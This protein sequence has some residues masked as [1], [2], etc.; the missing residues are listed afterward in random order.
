[1]GCEGI[2]S[3]LTV[4]VNIMLRGGDNPTFLKG[5]DIGYSHAGIKQDILAITLLSAAPP[6]VAGDIHDRGI[7]LTYSD[8]PKFLS[9][10]FS[11]F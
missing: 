4:I 11:D 8:S 7:D 10:N 2:V 9:H 5:F 3:T 6:L 1:M